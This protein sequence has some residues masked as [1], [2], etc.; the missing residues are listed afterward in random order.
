MYMLK[1]VVEKAKEFET[2]EDVKNEL[3]RLQSVKC[4]LK[5][6]KALADYESKMTQVLKEEQLIKEVRD[7]MEPKKM[8]VTT[9]S[10]EDIS[11]LNH[12]ETIKAIKSI[13]SKK[14]NEQYVTSNPLDNKEYVK[15]LEIEKMLLEHKKLVK[16]IEETVVKKSSINDL[17]EHLENVNEMSKEEL[18]EKMKEL[19]G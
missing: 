11:L 13:Q 14:C 19:L 18:I 15:A 3:K 6:Q 9:M 8:T 1:E 17:I 16:P 7:Y 12:D 4:R 2:V 5:K 10:A